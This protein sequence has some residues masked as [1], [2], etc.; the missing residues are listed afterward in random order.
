MKIYLIQYIVMLKP[1]KGN[2]KP[3][4]YKIYIYKSQEKD[5]WDI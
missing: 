2:I 4:L 1:T 5:E 3:L